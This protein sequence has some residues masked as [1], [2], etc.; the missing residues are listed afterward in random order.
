MPKCLEYSNLS[1][2]MDQTHIRLTPYFIRT[3]SASFHIAINCLALS[4]F[5]QLMQMHRPSCTVQNENTHC[6]RIDNSRNVAVNIERLGRESAVENWHPLHHIVANN[7]DTRIIAAGH[8]KNIY[9]KLEKY[10]RFSWKKTISNGNF[11]EF[12]SRSY[13]ILFALRSHFGTHLH[14]F[15]FGPKR[16]HHFRRTKMS[17][18]SADAVEIMAMDEASE[19]HAAECVCD[20]STSNLICIECKRQMFGRLYQPCEKHPLVSEFFI[21]STRESSRFRSA[22]HI[23]PGRFS[24]GLCSF[25]ILVDYLHARFEIVCVRRSINHST[26]GAGKVDR[27]KKLA[28]KPQ[29]KYNT[30]NLGCVP[31]PITVHVINFASNTNHRTKGTLLFLHHHF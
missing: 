7:F 22:I 26:T 2:F 25:V 11:A 17:R 18:A 20:R 31:P 5:H 29:P 12:A 9:T 24:Y 13:W 28:V 21:M 4:L 8:L 3:H 23:Y 16:I 1:N 6:Y 27:F 15:L 10:L 19:Q 14:R 30:S